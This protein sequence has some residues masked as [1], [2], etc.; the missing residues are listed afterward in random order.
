MILC[1]EV[2]WTSKTTSTY[3]MRSKGHSG[4]HSI[5]S[6]KSENKITEIKQES[7]EDI[8]LK[9]YG[10]YSKDDPKANRGY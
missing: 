4:E 5:E 8:L 7:K 6:D 1:H 9:K 3:C 2:I 10:P